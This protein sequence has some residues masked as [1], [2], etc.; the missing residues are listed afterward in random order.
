MNPIVVEN[1][2]AGTDPTV[3]DI[4]DAGPDTFKYGDQTILGYAVPF[5]VNL[6]QPVTFKIKLN[7]T[8]IPYHIDIYRLGYYGGK[9]ARKITTIIPPTSAFSQIQPTCLFDSATGLTD[10]GNWSA[11]AAWT[12]TAPL[13]SGV[14]L[15][16]LVREDIP[17]KGSHIV[18]VCARTAARRTSSL[19]PATRHGMPITAMSIR[20]MRRTR[21]NRSM[22]ME[23][24]TIPTVAP[25]R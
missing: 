5:S 23:P 3:W 14:Y 6:G 10:C 1:Q 25:T 24:A 8:P 19:R 18:F 13:I 9:G 7:P 11:S 12:P 22:A 20:R 17:S 2:L 4:P 15:A 21:K 16:K